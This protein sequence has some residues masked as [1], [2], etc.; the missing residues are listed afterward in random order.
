MCDCDKHVCCLV[1]RHVDGQGLDGVNWRK[2]IGGVV[3]H[4]QTKPSAGVVAEQI[5]RERYECGQGQGLVLLEVTTKAMR[6]Q[7]R[8]LHD[9]WHLAAGD[10]RRWMESRPHR[11]RR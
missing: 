7:A 8:V 5:A 6:V 2:P 4:Q 3:V 9:A 11:S 10:F 1:Y